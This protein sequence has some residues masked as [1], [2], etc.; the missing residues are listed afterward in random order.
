LNKKVAIDCLTDSSKS[1]GKQDAAVVID[2]IRSTTVAT[3]VIET[4]RKCF[5]APNVEEAVTIA[6]Q[7]ENPL[8]MGEIGGNMP[9]GFDLRNSPVDITNRKDTTRPVVLVSSSGIPLLSSLNACN[10][11]FVACLRN[12]TA[13]VNQ[14]APE[15]N[16]VDVLAAPTRGEFREED[17]LCCAWIAAGLI[18]QGFEPAD[19]KTKQLIEEWKNQPADVC[20][21]GNSAKY[22]RE[23][24]QENDLEFII[25]HT[26]DFN[27]ALLAKGNEIIKK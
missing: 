8:L 27:Y 2:V 21:S 19:E 24:G 3:T 20:C 16:N 18:K 15:Y 6:K 10:S 25:S 12:W 7:L 22:L 9:Y 4:G 13:T 11:L 26:N 14:I 5:F 23:T 1:Y 17:K